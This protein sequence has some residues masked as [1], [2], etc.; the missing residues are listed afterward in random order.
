MFSNPNV[1]DPSAELMPTSKEGKHQFVVNI[2]EIV[3][4]DDDD[5]DDDNDD[6]KENDFDN[7]T[8]F[9]SSHG[10]ESEDKLLVPE[11][12]KNSDVVIDIRSIDYESFHT[13]EVPDWMAGI[14]DTLQ[15]QFE[16]VI[17]S[18]CL[19]TRTDSNNEPEQH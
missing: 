17:S 18:Q 10:S 3:D 16:T 6:D 14:I 9:V 1:K 7:F 19:L 8:D 5:D 11:N 4:D 2:E 13:T 12:S 15:R